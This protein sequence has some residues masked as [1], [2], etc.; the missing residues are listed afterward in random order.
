MNL[1]YVIL[2]G[3]PKGRL[4]EQHD[5]YVGIGNTLKSLQPSMQAFWS[6]GEEQRF[7]IDSW[8]ILQNVD[9]YNVHIVPKTSKTQTEQLFFINLGGYLV[10]DMEEYHYKL[11]VVANSKSEATKKAKE[12]DFYKKFSFK[13]AE[14]HVDDH[15]GV[16]I[17]EIFSISEMLSPEFLD[18]YSIVL[19]K[20]NNRLQN[21]IKVG[22][23][24]LEKLQ[25]SDF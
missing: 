2:G 19:E 24:S 3:T 18:K 7:H 23:L 11:F 20:T 10:N 21:P 9:G 16:D 22:Y 17:D 6:P 15:H 12:T 25:K 5:V 13:G 1:Y 8:Q 14:S 4:T